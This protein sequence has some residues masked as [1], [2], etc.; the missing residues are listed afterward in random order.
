MGFCLLIRNQ[1]SL[2]LHVWSPA[3]IAIWLGMSYFIWIARQSIC[4]HFDIMRMLCTPLLFPWSKSNLFSDFI[5]G[6]IW[7]ICAR[8][9]STSFSIAIAFRS[10]RRCGCR[11]GA[12]NH[13]TIAPD[14]KCRCWCSRTY[15]WQHYSTACWYNHFSIECS[16]TIIFDY[17]DSDLDMTLTHTKRMRPWIIY[18]FEPA[19]EWNQIQQ[20]HCSR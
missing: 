18:I 9:F 13:Q 2:T 11:F 5:A 6:N 4:T 17:L 20:F 7:C 15:V 14:W 10:V 16:I 8:D 1:C 3:S 19:F 12:R